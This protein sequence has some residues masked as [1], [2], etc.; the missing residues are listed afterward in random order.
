[1]LVVEDGQ[2]GGSDA[3]DGCCSESG[4]LKGSEVREEYVVLSAWTPQGSQR[5]V[6]DLLL[7]RDAPYP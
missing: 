7:D 3:G 4:V 5:G 2:N 6:V 1:M